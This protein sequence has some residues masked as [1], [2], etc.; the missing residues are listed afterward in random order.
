MLS[1]DFVEAEQQTSMQAGFYGADVA[2]D[3]LALVDHQA[4]RRREKRLGEAG[5]EMISS[6]DGFGVEAVSKL[7]EENS[8]LRNDVERRGRGILREQKRRHE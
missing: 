7:D 2:L 4:A 5:M 6:F 3:F 1:F 8:T